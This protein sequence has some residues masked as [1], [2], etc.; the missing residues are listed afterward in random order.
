MKR[1]ALLRTKRMMAV[2][3]AASLFMSS[4]IIAFANGDSVAGVSGTNV[5]GTTGSAE[6]VKVEASDIDQDNEND[7]VE[8]VIEKDIS[9]GG[10]TVKSVDGSKSSSSDNDGNTVADV[11]VK[12]DVTNNEGTGWNESA[13]RA[14]AVSTSGTGSSANTKVTVEGDASAGNITVVGDTNAGVVAKSKSNGSNSEAHTEVTV[15]GE[16]SANGTAQVVG[17]YAASTSSYDANADHNRTA[18]TEVTVEKNVKTGVPKSGSSIGIQVISEAESNEKMTSTVTVKGDVSA[19]SE[20]GAPSTG[21]DAQSDG[22]GAVANVTVVGNVNSTSSGTDDY[23]WSGQVAGINVHGDK[24]GEVNI[25]VGG[26]VTADTRGYAFGINGVA[27]DADVNIKVGGDVTANGNNGGEAIQIIADKSFNVDVGRSVK[28]TGTGEE[29]VAINIK[30]DAGTS[31]RTYDQESTETPS[32]KVTVAEDVTSDGKAILV[33]K[34]KEESTIDVTVGGTVSGKEHNIVLG[35]DTGTDNLEITVW[36]VDTSNEKNVVDTYDNGNKYTRNT[37]AEKKI[38]YIIKVDSNDIKL[39][40]TTKVNDYDTAH[41]GNKVYLKVDIPTGYTAEFKDVNGNNNYQIVP[42]G[43]GGAYLVVPRG[44]GVYVG[45]NLMKSDTATSGDNSG[46]TNDSTNNS[47]T[48][49]PTDNSSTNT[50]AD[51]RTSYSSPSDSSSGGSG[52]GSDSSSSSAPGSPASA[53][54]TYTEKLND[55]VSALASMGIDTTNLFFVQS[56]DAFGN[57]ISSDISSVLTPV[58][59]LTAI[60]NFME[61]NAPTMGLDNFKGA[62]VVSLSSYFTGSA[63]DTVSVPV[64]SDVVSGQTYTVIFSD[65]T[66]MTVPCSM[67]GVLNIPFTKSAEGLTFIIYGTSLDPSLAMQQLMQKP[68][69]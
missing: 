57:T 42:D 48:G 39:E 56:V 28:Q 9:D 12:G 6:T 26:D 34:T 13:V 20:N 8:T 19:T 14:E 63:T 15:K 7:T 61:K 65:G 60:N 52:G 41:E 22:K 46:S 44:G 11:T 50:Q 66:T 35:S 24:G 3:I 29:A 62:G 4:G 27:G 32:I 55:V 68:V 16:V 69:G 51:S 43:E 53:P 36:K 38:N 23:N 10:L 49:S 25:E 5:T 18:S 31:Y 54:Q 30:D 58:D 45:V 1:K 67:N 47:P 37:E 33:D 17:V 64:V 59:R 21:I 40:G 2:I